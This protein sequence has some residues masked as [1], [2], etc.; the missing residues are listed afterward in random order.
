MNTNQKGFTLIELLVVIAIIGILASVVLVSLGT[1]RERARNA[2]AQASMTSMRAE[3]ELHMQ[4][5]GQY[6]ADLCSTRLTALRTAVNNAVTATT[7]CNPTTGPSQA[8]AASIQLDGTGAPH[9]CVDST[10]FSGTRTTALGTA[11]V[12]PG[13]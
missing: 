9:F 5:N 12:C 6:P 8:W 2:S 4:P 1:A 13:T 3:A 10:G 7:V 11:T